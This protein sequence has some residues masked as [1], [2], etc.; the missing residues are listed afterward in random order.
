MMIIDAFSG[1]IVG[2]VDFSGLKQKVTQHPELDVLNG[3]AYHPENKTFFVTGKKWDRLFE[4]RIVP[5]P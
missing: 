5:K 1:A 4:V 2:I 3:V